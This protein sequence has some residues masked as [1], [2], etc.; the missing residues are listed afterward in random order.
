MSKLKLNAAMLMEALE[1]LARAD[2]AIRGLVESVEILTKDKS[3]DLEAPMIRKTLWPKLAN[4]LGN[5][6]AANDYL[7]EKK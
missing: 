7:K 1:K 2:Q 6:A 3:F 4:V 5:L